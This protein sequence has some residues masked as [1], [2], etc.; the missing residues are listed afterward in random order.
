MAFIKNGILIRR[1]KDCGIT[2]DM[3]EFRRQKCLRNGKWYTHNICIPCF[4]ERQHENKVA[5]YNRNR[6]YSITMAQ[7]WNI[8][9]RI[10]F[11]KRRKMANIKKRNLRWFGQ[12]NECSG[13]II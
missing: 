13:K 4:K 7:E 9:N 11:N 1:C 3:I 12:L 2:S 6:A 10:R 5:W 8:E